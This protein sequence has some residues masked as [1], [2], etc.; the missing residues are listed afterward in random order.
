MKTTKPGFCQSPIVFSEYP[1]N[2]KICI[3]T[4]I[5]HYLEITRLTN[6]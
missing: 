6:H 1:A 4:T 2:R 3:V 5:N